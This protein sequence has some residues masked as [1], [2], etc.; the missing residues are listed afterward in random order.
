MTRPA[1]PPRTTSVA[2]KLMA[3]L[4]GVWVVLGC[5]SLIS[6]AGAGQS[7][8]S[9]FYRTA[10]AIR[11]GVPA[12]FYREL[13]PPTGLRHCIAPSGTML[14]SYMP[15]LSPRGAAAV[16]AL[17]NVG[18]LALA[19]WCLWRIFGHLERQR[20]IYQRTWLWA[21][22]A[23]A[24]LNTDNLQVGQFSL[25]FTTCWLV[26]LAVDNGLLAATML[27]LPAAIKLYP[28]VLWAV[29]LG[30]RRYRQALWLIPAGV[31]VA[32]ILPLP[33][34]GG[35][36][37][38]MWRGFFGTVLLGGEKSRMLDMINP[39]LPTNQSLDVTLLRYLADLPRF[40]QAHPHF[41]HLSLDP[42]L[43]M[44]L[45]LALKACLLVVTG[46]AAWRLGSRAHTQPRWTALLMMALWSA[47]LYLLIPETKARYAVYTF[48]AWLPLLAMVASRRHRPWAYAGACL[49]LVAGLASVLQIVQNESR[50][51]GP[52][53]WATIAVW[54]M[55][56]R[57]AWQARVAA[58]TNRTH[59]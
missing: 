51:Y 45:I 50:L 10:L 31:L 8:F 42:G 7:D 33:L 40:S 54:V 58:D 38:E 11:G 15:W 28:A 48:P 30:L 46:A 53:C 1:R 20:R 36:L 13:D 49:L 29:P 2:A 37:L 34:Y 44:G 56:L 19:A 52:S 3:A 4:A 35:H 25:L 18:L 9:V 43:V 14:F 57:V 27:M 39:Y 55:L 47:T 22:V 24:I 26:Y 17:F 5:L 32:F 41:P 16:W 21:V 6:R 59:A 23:L 12:E